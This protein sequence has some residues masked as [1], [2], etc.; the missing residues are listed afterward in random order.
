[1][2]IPQRPSSAPPD[3][4]SQ[5][6]VM[7][8]VGEHL[9]SRWVLLGGVAAL[10]ISA[11]VFSTASSYVTLKEAGQRRADAWLAGRRDQLELTFG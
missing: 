8:R 9:G 7:A 6:R 11:G 2:G 1:M 5:T 4:V 3:D 10:L